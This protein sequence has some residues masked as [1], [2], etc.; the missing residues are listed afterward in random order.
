[1][2]SWRDLKVMPR[3]PLTDT[4]HSKLLELKKLSGVGPYTLV[5]QWDDK[6]KGLSA[7]T[8]DNWLKRRVK[9][10]DKT[11]YEA[12]IKY[13]ENIDV[14]IKITSKMR[15]AL[16][17]ER[18]RVGVGPEP[19]F[20]YANEEL[21]NRLSIHTINRWMRGEVRSA[22]QAH[23]DFV[24][25]TYSRLTP[26]YIHQM[27]FLNKPDKVILTDEI[28]ANLQK[29]RDRSSIGPAKLLRLTHDRPKGLTSTHIMNWINGKVQT[30]PKDYLNF[31]QKAWRTVEP[32]IAVTTSMIKLMNKEF[33]RTG[34]SVSQVIKLCQ[35]DLGSN[36]SHVLSAL[37]LGKRRSIAKKTW[38]NIMQALASLP[39]SNL[40]SKQSTPMKDNPVSCNSCGANKA[41]ISTNRRPTLSNLPDDLA[42]IQEKDRH[43]MRHHRERTGMSATMLL[44][45]F[46]SEKPEK[47][48][49]NMISSWIN[50]PSKYASK[51]RLLWV[52]EKWCK[53]PDKPKNK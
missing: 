36:P 22:N 41:V 39:N 28:R 11:A 8:V 13:W 51:L 37:K 23:F 27:R 26:K 7:T 1:M 44:R 47:L 40:M 29:F 52:I 4:M 50:G 12:V 5:N 10:V 9:S 30:A 45:H 24:M 3:I 15:K 35:S 25:R 2:F 17:A 19:L 21:P 33:Q 49:A 43:T 32:E 46:E 18:N 34:A 42:L 6:P 53:L 20:K 48:S 14:V 31:V 16:I 38:Q